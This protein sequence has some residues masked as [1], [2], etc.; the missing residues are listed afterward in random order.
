VAGRRSALVV[1]IDAYVPHSPLESCVADAEAVG[2]ILERHE[3]GRPNF[4]VIRMLGSE[5]RN[6]TVTR[7]A[8]RQELANALDQALDHDFVFY[9]SGHGEVHKQFGAAI[10]TQEGEEVAMDEIL[11]LLNNAKFL[12]ATVVVD[13]CFA[14]SLG[15]LAGLAGRTFL[16]K[17]VA[18]IGASRDD[19]AA[20]ASS[21]LSP[22]TEVL[23]DGLRGGAADLRGHVTAAG[24]YDYTAQSFSAT[25]QSPVFRASIDLGEPLREVALP[26]R[27]NVM[28]LIPTI[29][30]SDDDNYRLKKTDAE[31]GRR[32]A[33][34]DRFKALRELQAGGLVACGEGED[35]AGAAESAGEVRLTPRGR[36]ASRL[37]RQNLI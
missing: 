27:A 12:Q 23:V 35:L 26:V 32:S 8:L 28:R 24:L 29:F 30:S 37:V 33:R 21:A 4:D 17:N 36:Q 10:V 18:I 19:Q 5:A 22:F 14:G 3:D 6:P 20:M 15:Q 34:R 7:Q 11:T 31:T 13:T 16:K 2:D 9:F 25:Q 1:G